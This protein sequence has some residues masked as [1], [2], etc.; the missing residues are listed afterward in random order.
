MHRAGLTITGHDESR[1]LVS[2]QILRTL[3]DPFR[4]HVRR[5]RELAGQTCKGGRNLRC[6]GGSHSNDLATGNAQT[7]IGVH[8]RLSHQR[9]DRVKAAHA[10]LLDPAALCEIFAVQV[11][12]ALAA[13]EIA[14]ERKHRLGLI[15][16][17]I[18]RHGPTRRQRSS[19][20]VHI[21]INCVVG[22]PFGLR[23][24]LLNRFLHPVTGRRTAA[25]HE[26]SQ[27]FATV[28]RKLLGYGGQ[29]IHRRRG[30]NIRPAAGETLG[31][32][33]IVE[34][35]YRSL[36]VEISAAVAVRM[37]GVALNLGRTPITGTNEQRNAAG[38]GRHGRRVVTRR[39]V[40]V[41]F[42]QFGEWIN[43]L[44]RLAAARAQDS[45]ASESSR[46]RHELH[47][48]AAVEVR[49]ARGRR[50]LAIQP[51]LRFRGVVELIDALPVFHR[52]RLGTLRGNRFHR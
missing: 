26:E 33:R 47:E 37:V 17:E 18:G 8:A 12:F 48:I 5:K 40:D 32:I 50:E 14:V 30:R 9:L 39:A 44:L 21:K 34:T 29:L 52:L 11:G 24:L 7:M 23:E 51:R 42:R 38:A 43:L 31:A 45:D 49:L 4:L 3:G 28:S 2:D 13:D 27:S 35:E 10:A 46:R 6:D 41:A 36:G 19:L 20:A 15:E 1:A 22:E 16:T 25:L